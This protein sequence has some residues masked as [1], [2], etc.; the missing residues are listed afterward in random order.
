M[1][2]FRRSPASV[3]AATG[4][5]SVFVFGSNEAGRHGA[6]S[7]KEALLRHGAIRGQGI[8]RQGNSYAIPTKNRWL[9]PLPLVAIRQHVNN[10]IDYARGL[11]N[12]VFEVVRIGCGLAG[13]TDEEIAPMFAM[14]PVNVFLPKEWPKIIERFH[15]RP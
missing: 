10:F 12:E 9:D 11:P 5:V 7:A 6:G 3:D 13:Y 2:S 4:Q 14:A 1:N 15:E 8:G